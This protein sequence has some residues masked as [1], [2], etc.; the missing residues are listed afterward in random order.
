MVCGSCQ[1]RKRLA[2][3]QGIQGITTS[4]EGTL[5]LVGLL[6]LFGIFILTKK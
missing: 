4:N 1:E 3:Q 6:A 5:A 2:E